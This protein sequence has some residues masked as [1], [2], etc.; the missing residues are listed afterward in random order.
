MPL[1]GDGELFV[2]DLEALHNAVFG[3]FRGNLQA[4]SKLVDRLMMARIDWMRSGAEN[5]RQ[6]GIR[7][8]GDFMHGLCRIDARP[9]RRAMGVAL[10]MLD[11]GTA[12]MYIEQLQ[13]AAN[14][15]HRQIAAKSGAQ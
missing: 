13:T 5:H 2:R 9:F 1:N 15:Q 10:E 14:G 7:L 4:R 12:L 6:L 8:D 11:E 3:R